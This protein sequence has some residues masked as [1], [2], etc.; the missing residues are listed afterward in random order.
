ME[1]QSP[2]VTGAAINLKP[3]QGLK[4][5]DTKWHGS[6]RWEAAINL[7]PYQGLKLNFT[8]IYRQFL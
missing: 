5:S 8:R 6:P 4:H 3:Y 2:A 7:K 1:K